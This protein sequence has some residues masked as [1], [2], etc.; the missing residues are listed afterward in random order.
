M[1][2]Q[3]YLSIETFYF[4]WC[5]SKVCLLFITKMNI[6]EGIDCLTNNETISYWC[7][8][9]CALN[10][11]R[12]GKKKNR[13]IHQREY[14][15]LCSNVRF[16]YF[17]FLWHY[18]NPKLN[19]WQIKSNQIINNECN[20]I[21]NKIRWLICSLTKEKNGHLYFLEKNCIAVCSL[22]DAKEREKE[23]EK[24]YTFETFL[25]YQQWK[26]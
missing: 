9:A 5:P 25:L 19:I 10:E 18:V 1:L 23:K 20:L 12:K 6:K 24:K 4:E 7:L 11:K 14:I 17:N 13:N 2:C 22:Q 15:N 16:F 21:E 26:W 8:T 3:R